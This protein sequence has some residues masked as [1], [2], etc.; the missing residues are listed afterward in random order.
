MKI[1]ITGA[2]GFVGSNLIRHFQTAGHEVL[3]LVRSVE[4]A[5]L[6]RNIVKTIVVDYSNPGPLYEAFCDMDVVVHNAGKTKAL[7][8]DEMMQANVSTTDNIITAINSLSKVTQLIYISSQAASRPSYGNVPVKESDAPAPLTNYGKSKLAA[9]NLIRKKCNQPYTIIRPCSVYGDNDKDFLSL[10][11]MVNMGFS[12]QIGK[13][14]K[15]LNMIHVNELAEFIS[16]CLMNER[17]FGQIIFATDTKV[18][19]QSQ[20][21]RSIARAL[22]KSP[23]YVVIPEVIA[24]LAFTLGGWYGK[25]F[26]VAVMVN[27]DKMKEIMAP[28]WVADTSKA[29]ELLNW[30]PTPDFDLNIME[31]VKCYRALG[32]L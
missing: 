1:A 15:L 31:T 10:F 5:N 11:K 22:H 26:S 13:T 16:L 29:K 6:L 19:H 27:K 32:W 23:K 7:D 18:Y 28:G 8:M 21:M 3:A 25:L 14:D 24:K 30:N 12:F 4:S 2:N 20:I 9:E 17:V